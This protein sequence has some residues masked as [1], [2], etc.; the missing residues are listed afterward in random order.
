MLIGNKS[1]LEANR[2]VTKEEGE[3]FAKENNLFFLETSAKTAQNV[4]EVK[5]KTFLR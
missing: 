3:H 2:A 4:E 1:D 5:T